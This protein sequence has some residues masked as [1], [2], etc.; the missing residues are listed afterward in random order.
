[1]CRADII[2]QGARSLECRDELVN[3]RGRRC[4]TSGT[5]LNLYAAHFLNAKVRLAR[6]AEQNEQAGEGAKTGE[7]ALESVV[8]RAKVERQ[9]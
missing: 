8:H 2:P 6:T 5:R 7:S 1:M 9:N 4:P 3:L